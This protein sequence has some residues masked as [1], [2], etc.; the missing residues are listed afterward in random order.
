MLWD[1]IYLAGG[2]RN[3]NITLGKNTFTIQSVKNFSYSFVTVPS[4]VNAVYLPS[5][6][7][8][9]RVTNLSGGNYWG[10]PTEPQVAKSLKEIFTNDYHSGFKTSIRTDIRGMLPYFKIGASLDYFNL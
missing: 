2:F 4:N 8:V 3:R 5:S 7:C 6:V 9:K 1:M 10:N